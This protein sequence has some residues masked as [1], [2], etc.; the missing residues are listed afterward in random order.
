MCPSYIK[1]SM[2]C[3]TSCRDI[4]VSA[5]HPTQKHIVIVLDHGASMSDVQMKTAKSI[6]KHLL[7][8]LHYNDKVRD[9]VRDG[10]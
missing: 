5:L 7:A 10:L 9:H 1:E 6:A 3:D 2:F 8:S 4:F